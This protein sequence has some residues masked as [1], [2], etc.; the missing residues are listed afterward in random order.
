M[1]ELKNYQKETLQALC[2]FL[3]EA[4]LMPVEE[5]FTR[6]QQRQNRQPLPYLHHDFGQ[7]PYV[8][9]RL[10]TGGGKTVLASYAVGLAKRAY[11]EQDFPIVLWLVPTNNLVSPSFAK[12]AA[13]LTDKMVQSM[14]FDPLEI[15]QHLQHGNQ[16]AAQGFQ[17]WLLEDSSLL[18]VSETYHYAF[19]PGLYPARVPFYR[20]KYHFGKHYYPNIEDLKNSGE[21]FTVEY[22]GEHLQ[23]ADDAREK[24][25]IGQCWA[26][27]SGGLFL[28]ALA[29]DAQDR[30]VRQQ[31]NHLFH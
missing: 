19:K 25:I 9:L 21:E 20:G 7:V 31:L 17:H 22:K 16:A 29:K 4:R 13:A 28:L 1:F 30:D 15:P 11:L 8:C 2:E 12:A 24:A 18:D 3:E 26:E 5:A 27:K 6:A 10:P 14:G 23:T